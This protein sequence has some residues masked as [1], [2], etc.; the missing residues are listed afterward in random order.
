MVK[1]ISGHFLEFGFWSFSGVWDLVLGSLARCIEIP[2]AHFP[3][4]ETAL[5]SFRR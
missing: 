5:H 4:S 2:F 1:G 3:P